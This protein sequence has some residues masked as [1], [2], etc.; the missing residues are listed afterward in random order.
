MTDLDALL[1][2][3]RDRADA[4]AKAQPAE[5]AKVE[6][7]AEPVAEAAA[8]PVEAEA[9]EPAAEAAEEPVAKSEG[10]FG[11]SF[12][13]TLADGSKAP[14]I[15]GFAVI[16]SLAAKVEA[17]T[18]Q[19]DEIKAAPAA[20]PATFDFDGLKKSFDDGMTGVAS[21]T[22]V[23][24]KALG[25]ALDA[26]TASNEKS[27]ELTTRVAE[28]TAKA[29]AQD[30]VM[31]SLAAKLDAFGTTG[32]GRRATVSVHEKPSPA[33][34][35]QDEPTVGDLFA[36]ANALVG[37]GKL[38]AVDVSRIVAAVNHGRGIP[39]EYAAHFAA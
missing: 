16:K 32:A 19:L 5:E 6:V 3:L 38:N 4:L 28:L 24:A 12:E 2:G 33:A 22:E 11:E 37:A 26:L 36:K 34:V 18:A 17:L 35:K 9:S 29:A 10:D 30:D 14:A 23:M 31:K 39:T 27:A 15:D 13:V 7:A 21:Q 8:E 20:E 25:A 1:S